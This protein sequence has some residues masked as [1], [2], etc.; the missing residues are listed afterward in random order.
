MTVM[1]E[2]TARTIF[3]VLVV[4]IVTNFCTVILAIAEQIIVLD[5][6]VSGQ[7]SFVF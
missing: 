3:I 7:K 2:G 4:L 1:Q 6:L 5:V